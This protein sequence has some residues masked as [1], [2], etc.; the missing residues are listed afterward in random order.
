MSAHLLASFQTRTAPPSGNFLTVTPPP[1]GGTDK[2]L[3]LKIDS[4]KTA[5]LMSLTF[6]TVGVRK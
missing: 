5:L 2:N 4:L 1:T 3:K 6:R